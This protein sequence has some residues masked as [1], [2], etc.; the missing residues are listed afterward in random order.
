MAETRTPIDEERLLRYFESV[1]RMYS[2]EHWRNGA[3]MCRRWL[4]LHR[5]GAT[6]GDVNQFLAR[7][8]AASDSGSGWL[9]LGMRFRPWARSQGFHA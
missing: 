9:K 4:Q 7:L 1:D 2:G 6:Q 3:E 5:D 8:E